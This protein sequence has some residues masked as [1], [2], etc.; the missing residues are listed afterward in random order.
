MVFERALRRELSRLAIGVFAAFFAIMVATQLIR[1]LNDAVGGRVAPEA[2]AALLGFTALQYLP[3][4]LGLTLFTT[5]LVTL[6]RQYRDSEMVI[7]FASGQS[8]FAWVGPILR[9]AAPV[10]AVVAALAFAFTP[11]ALEKSAE[12]KEKARARSQAAHISPGVFR[13]ADYGRRVLFVEGIDDGDFGIRG[14]FVREMEDGQLTVV[15]ANEGKTRTVDNGDRFLVLDN[16]RRYELKPGSPEMRILAFDSYAARIELKESYQPSQSAKTAT[17]R[18]LL[19]SRELAYRAELG[20]RIG[21]PVS[22][23]I[24]SLLAI[25]LAYVNPRGGRSWG[26]VL[27]LLVFMIYNNVQSITQSWVGRGIVAPAWGYWVAHVGA[28]ILFFSM[29][30]RQTRIVK[31]WRRRP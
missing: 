2:V 17:T 14:V 25:P 3:T 9:F 11:W 22:V 13:E 21:L 24:L 6:S 19:A 7:W 12:Y 27:A 20:W 28:L 30:W 18:R 5:I 4:L 31:P 23:A 29:T 10:V 16:G 8:L 1:L 15:T 26:I